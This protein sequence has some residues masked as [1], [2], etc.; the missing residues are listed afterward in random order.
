MNMPR[1]ALTLDQPAAWRLLIHVC[2]DLFTLGR[3]SEAGLRFHLGALGYSER[4]IAAEVEFL[5][6]RMAA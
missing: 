3:L 6:G 5:R 4:E 2:T 1:P